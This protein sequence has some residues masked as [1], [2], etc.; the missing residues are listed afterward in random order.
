MIESGDFDPYLE[1]ERL[2]GNIGLAYGLGYIA[3]S[4][5][6]SA[7]WALTNE[8]GLRIHFLSASSFIDPFVL[9]SAGLGLVS[10]ENT[11]D[12]SVFQ[13]LGVGLA[14]RFGNAYLGLRAEEA[15]MNTSISSWPSP[16]TLPLAPF[17]YILS[18]GAAIG[19][20]P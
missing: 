19:P 16:S 6:G 17:R 5:G 11:Q 10:E 13:N 7:E 18:V 2:S 12:L 20:Q 1:I 14:V 4:G 3:G 9:Y 8:I 15:F